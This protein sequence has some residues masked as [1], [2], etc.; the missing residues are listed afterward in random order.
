MGR[1]SASGYA[2]LVRLGMEPPYGLRVQTYAPTAAGWF[3]E[4]PL[5]VAAISDIHFGPPYMTD[6]RLQMIVDTTNRLGA[7]LIVLLGDFGATHRTKSQHVGDMDDM[8]RV[9]AGLEAPLGV[10]AVLGNHDWSHDA[11][12]QRRGRGPVAAGEALTRVGVRVLHNEVVCIE[13]GGKSFWLAGLG[14][15]LA[16]RGPTQRGHDDLPGTLAQLSDEAPAI[17][18]AHEPDIFPAVP[19]RF[20]LTLSGHTHGG[21]IRIFGR[22]PIVPSRFGSRFAHGHIVEG[23]RHLVVSAGVGVSGIP[24]RIGVPPEITLVELGA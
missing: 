7:D 21:Q 5:T 3:E 22:T 10:F 8:A 6:Q 19:K 12:A 15:Q 11:H 16:R 20:A 1:A 23:G 2:M 4:L 18:L 14:D 17:L 24:L 13:H 9:V